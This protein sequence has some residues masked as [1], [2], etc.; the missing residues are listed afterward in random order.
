MYYGI[1]WNDVR[2]SKAIAITT[3]VLVA[4]A[5]MLVSLAGILVVNL[6]GAIDN[7]MERAKTPHFQ[8]M[9][10]GEID[11]ARLS[12]FAEANGYVDDFQVLEFLNIDGSQIFLNGESLADSF[13]DHGLSVQSE[14]FDY[15]LNL[16]GD[17]IEAAD[18]QI[19]VPLMYMEN[20]AAT[21]GGQAV[22]AGKTFDVA[23]FFR[24]SQMNS[25]L[26]SSKRFVVSETD[27]AALRAQGDLEYLIQF[28]LTDLTALSAFAAAY[29]EAGLE[30][31]GPTI[32]YPL[33]RMINALSD[34]MMIAV[35][36]FVSA[37]VVAIAFMCIRFT[38][39]AKVEDEY[40]EIGVMKAIGL[41]LSDIQRIYLAKYAVLA[42]VGC[43][44]GFGLAL[45]FRG[46]LLE[47]IRLYMGE[48]ESTFLASLAGVGGVVFVFM[49]I[50]AY[51]LAILRRFR[52][53]SAAE[54][55]RFG[56][57][58][59]PAIGAKRMRLNQNKILN[60]N[61]FLGVKDVLARKGLYGTMLGV[62][63]ILAFI[64]VV[65]QN[66]YNTIAAESFIRYM[67]IGS[68]DI[69]MDIQ[70]AADPAGRTREI[71]GALAADDAVAEYVVLRTKTFPMELDDGSQ[72]STHIELG[73]HTVFPVE[74]LHGSAP[75]AADELALSVMY[76]DELAKEVGDNITVLIGDEPRELKVTG[77]YSDITNGGKTAKA[78]FAAD[79]A[80]ILRSVIY[81]QLVDGSLVS[82][83]TT[84][85]AAQ[86][87]AAKV[88]GIEEYVS[89]TFGSTIGA[90]ETASRAAVLVA[91][92]VA[93]LVTV[94][95]MKMLVAKDRYG[96]AVMKAL[97]FTNSDIRAQYIARSVFV[98]LLGVAV[99]TVL[100]NTLG[101]ALVG[102]AIA[103]FGA[104][105]FRFVVNPLFAYVLS[106]LMMAAAVL[107]ATIMG[108]SAAGEISISANIKE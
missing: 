29:S 7:L 51:V 16:D 52:R 76:A 25:T 86:F 56:A 8:Q 55:I 75:M 94:L 28:R 97:G 40:R 100:A 50:V 46:M 74:Y 37:L 57:S 77:V 10:L 58:Q 102:L 99:G 60:T 80:E 79:G 66:L 23:G 92:A 19:Y 15:L 69:R 2:R 68:A 26:A 59:E 34:G 105:S 33:F 88:T 83:K 21:V 12:A 48:S 32:T 85:Y 41:R 49:A 103:S 82:E 27:F 36:L 87:D 91:L 4:A 18:G 38:L 44:L 30:A 62:L 13:Q 64:I 96:I 90:V 72:V 78:A 1:V 54:A 63:I 67:G 101:E 70:Q 35:I 14:R 9:H 95:F 5:A 108:T 71:A 98:L 39:L 53:I 47:N 45:A 43:V 106:P 81:V 84:A 31:N 107:A 17:V 24:D 42:L 89:Q 73:D 93:M 104:A 3:L 61:V 6:S 20:N 65:P 22:I 11:F